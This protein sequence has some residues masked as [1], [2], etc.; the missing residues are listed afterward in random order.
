[1]SDFTPEWLDQRESVDRR[2]RDPVL[3]AALRTRFAAAGRT[4][5]CE[6]GA[7]AGS[8]LRALAPLL[9]E[10]QEWHLIDSDPD[11]L[12]A[13][14]D[15]L[16]S[17]ADACEQGESLILHRGRQEI[18]VHFA[19]RDLSEEIAPA[20][21]EA[22]LVAASAL[23][24]LAG[25]AWLGELARALAANRQSFYV[26]LTFCGGLEADPPQ[27]LDSALAAAFAAHQRND[28]GLGGVA[29]GPAAHGLLVAALSANGADVQE[30]DSS[31]HLAEGEQALLQ[32]MVRDYAAVALE[33]GLL[34]A[35]AVAAW[36][37][38]HLARCRRLS[39]G[40]RD[41]L[42]TWPEAA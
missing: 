18:A 37:D 16:A 1:M 7:G 5:V 39:I 29:A 33:T 12:A 13:A 10:R 38:A 22:E 25:P 8:L 26:S 42:A 35:T 23:F 24:D 21:G 34:P 27:Q 9:S 20:L 3:L 31:W 2:S 14:R 17:W 15:K 28:K 4:T 30:G 32:R 36:R 11:N 19:E 41:L 6:L 40:H